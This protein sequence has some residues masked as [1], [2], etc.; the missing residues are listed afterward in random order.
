M[1]CSKCTSENMGP[2]SAEVAIHFPG[3]A[4]IN[5]PIVWTFPKLI[6]CLDCGHT[7]FTVPDRELT[8][9][10]TG[11]PVEGALVFGGSEASQA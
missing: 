1:V 8:V 11:A 4:G 2:F 7:D 5:K 6:V 3:R 9:L 10:V